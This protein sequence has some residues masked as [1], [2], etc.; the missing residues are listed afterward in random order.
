MC[1]QILAFGNVKMGQNTFYNNKTPGA[2]RDLDIE[3]FLASKNIY[4]DEKNY[5]YFIG[6]SYNDYKFNIILHIML[7]KTSAYIKSYDRQSKCM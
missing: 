6:Y 2:L 4:F 7:R 5:K 3:K 1:K